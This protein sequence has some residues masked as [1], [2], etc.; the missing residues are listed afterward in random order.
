MASKLLRQ[1]QKQGHRQRTGKATAF[2]FSGLFLPNTLQ[3]RYEKDCGCG[4]TLLHATPTFRNR[5]KTYGA[6]CR[7][8]C[9]TIFS[10][11]RRA[12]SLIDLR[13]LLTSTV[14]KC[15]HQFKVVY[16]T[17]TKYLPQ[18]EYSVGCAPKLRSCYDLKYQYARQMVLEATVGLSSRQTTQCCTVYNSAQ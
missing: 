16:C 9:L 2:K 17:T 6:P 15:K 7:V 18:F 5:S 11:V 1:Q 4:S 3:K 12:S 10:T 13:V 14:E 8:A